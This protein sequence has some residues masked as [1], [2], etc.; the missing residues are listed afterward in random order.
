[1]KL[2]AERKVLLS[3]YSP[4]G[5]TK[6]LEDS[7]DRTWSGQLPET[8]FYEF[9]IVSNASEPIDYE[10]DITVEGSTSSESPTNGSTE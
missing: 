3:I 7:R 9:S 8:G 6:L 1:V 4:T 5:Q 2:K 10:F